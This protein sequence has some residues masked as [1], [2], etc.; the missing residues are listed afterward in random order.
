MPPLQLGAKAAPRTLA[1]GSTNGRGTGGHSAAMSQGGPGVRAVR[2]IGVTRSECLRPA[3]WAEYGLERRLQPARAVLGTARVVRPPNPGW[4]RPAATTHLFPLAPLRFDFSTIDRRVGKNRPDLRLYMVEDFPMHERTTDP[5]ETAVPLPE[6]QGR[7]YTPG[8]SEQDRA[9]T[10]AEA[11]RLAGRPRA[12]REPLGRVERVQL[13]VLAGMFVLVAAVLSAGAIA[14][15]NLSGQILG[16]RTEMREE[17]GGLRTE[18]REEIGGLRAEMREEIGELSDRMGQL[19]ERMTRVE[20]LI[21]THLVPASNA[22]DP[23]GP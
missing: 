15:T 1:G 7:S 3:C 10:N 2:H 13:T 22:R 12:S 4:R 6:H 23:V 8:A 11:G 19:S 21:A 14:F 9:M 18:M 16:L 5:A 17:M 20:T